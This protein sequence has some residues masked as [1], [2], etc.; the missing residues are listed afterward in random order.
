MNNRTSDSI[1]GMLEIAASTCAICGRHIVLAR[2]GKWCPA[3]SIA[4]HQE[5]DSKSTCSRCGGEY[6][7]PEPPVVDVAR[8]AMI[9]RCLRANTQE[10]PVAILILG[11]LLLLFLGLIYIAMFYN[12]E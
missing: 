3:C 4:V 10:S 9:P 5:C 12:S 8:E 7:A 2:E 1:Q 6:R 11:V